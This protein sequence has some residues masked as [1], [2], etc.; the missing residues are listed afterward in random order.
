[1]TKD[2]VIMWCETGLEGI[3]DITGMRQHATYAMLSNTSHPDIAGITAM[4]LRARL[5]P[6][7]NY[8]IYA[9]V[10]DDIDIEMLY[11]SF[12]NDPQ[13]IVDIIRDKGTPILK[14]S[15]RLTKVIV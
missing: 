7:R 8:E 6:Q 15:Q 9:L 13:W 4:E 1:M 3:L 10:T 14:A 11:A 5:N 12:E 2:Y